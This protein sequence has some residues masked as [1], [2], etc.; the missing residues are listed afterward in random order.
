M[1]MAMQLKSGQLDDLLHHN[2][3][4]SNPILGRNIDNKNKSKKK[5]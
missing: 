1:G 3:H 4:A 2:R 5:K